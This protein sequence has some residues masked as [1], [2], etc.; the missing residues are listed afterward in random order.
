MTHTIYCWKKKKFGTI[1]FAFVKNKFVFYSWLFLSLKSF[2]FIYSAKPD[3]LKFIIIEKEKVF[4]EKIE[5]K[6]GIIK[7]KRGAHIKQNKKTQKTLSIGRKVW[8]REEIYI[9]SYLFVD[10]KDSFLF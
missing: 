7:R 5:Q 4:E 9:I 10:T 3:F 2:Y 8:K 6:D 1:C